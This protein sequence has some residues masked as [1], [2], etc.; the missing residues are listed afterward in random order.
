MTNEQFFKLLQK[1]DWTYMMS[2]DHRYYTKGSDESRVLQ[3]ASQEDDL[4]KTMLRDYSAFVWQ[5]RDNP[6]ARPQLED[7]INV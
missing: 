4:R 2:D 7:Y 5:T 6:I 3:A 1:H